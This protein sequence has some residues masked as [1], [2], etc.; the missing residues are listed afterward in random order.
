MFA[1]IHFSEFFVRGKNWRFLPICDKEKKSSTVIVCKRNRFHFWIT[2]KRLQNF[3]NVEARILSYV[4]IRVI[5]LI[6][7]NNAPTEY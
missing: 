3:V 1:Q 4:L 2:C 5:T 7:A 6:S